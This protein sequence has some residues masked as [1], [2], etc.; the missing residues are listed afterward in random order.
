MQQYQVGNTQNNQSRA[1]SLH[2]QYSELRISFVSNSKSQ[3]KYELH[4]LAGSSDCEQCTE[5]GVVAFAD[6]GV[7]PLAVV[8]EVFHTAVAASTVL[9]C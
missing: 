1:Y 9:G 6:A 4:S 2:Y 3:G 7:E 5:P 8:V